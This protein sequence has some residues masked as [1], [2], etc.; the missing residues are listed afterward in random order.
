[1]CFATT[2]AL[3]LA[4]C[5]ISK[6]TQT[7]N[8]SKEN[9]TKLGSD[10]T[11]MEPSHVVAVLKCKTPKYGYRDV[12]PSNEVLYELRQHTIEETYAGIPGGESVTRVF[13]LV[14]PDG[15]AWALKIVDNGKGH[16]WDMTYNSQ[17]KRIYIVHF[18]YDSDRGSFRAK[19]FNICVYEVDPETTADLSLIRVRDQT[20]IKSG[21]RPFQSPRPHGTIR[22]L[23]EESLPKNSGNAVWLREPKA[24]SHREYISIFLSRSND[25]PV[26][27]RYSMSNHIQWSGDK[28]ALKLQF[29]SMEPIR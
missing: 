24:V 14:K 18:F 27:F 12:F 19:P 23:P 11:K 10:N 9:F 22:G 6:N 4:V 8:T 2:I 17:T 26:E 7:T 13:Y 28:S 25:D 16:S 5:P 1:M 3:V 20:L 29:L 15:I 21:I